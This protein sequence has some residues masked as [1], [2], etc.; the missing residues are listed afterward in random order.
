MQQ[1]GMIQPDQFVG[2]FFHGGFTVVVKP[3][4]DHDGI[5]G[6][7]KQQNIFIAFHIGGLQDPVQ[8][9]FFVLDVDDGSLQ[10]QRE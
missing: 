9:V 8:M 10:K 7:E 3:L 1:L 6:I 5:A 2:H 4:D